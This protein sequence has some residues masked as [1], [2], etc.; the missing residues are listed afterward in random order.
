MNF[1]ALR[2][3]CFVGSTNYVLYSLQNKCL[4]TS[5]LK[6]RGSFILSRHLA[7]QLWS[8]PRLN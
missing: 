4:L 6:G 5:G 8:A 1:V 2:T 7:T 3:K